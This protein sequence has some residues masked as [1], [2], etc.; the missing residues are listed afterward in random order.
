MG[1]WGIVVVGRLV[2]PFQRGCIAVRIGRLG[3]DVDKELTVLDR[4]AR[5]GCQGNGGGDIGYGEDFL[6][7]R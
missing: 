5:F 3:A 7:P 4:A 6:G 2:F 1:A